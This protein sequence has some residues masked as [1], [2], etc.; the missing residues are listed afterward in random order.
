M[1][2]SRRHDSRLGPE[3]ARSQSQ[4]A[5]IGTAPDDHERELAVLSAILNSVAAWDTFALGSQCL[6]RELAEALGQGAG[7]LLVPKGDYLLRRAIWSTPNIEPEA[8]GGIGAARISRGA[9]LAGRAWE[10]GETV[11]SPPSGRRQIASRSE[12]SAARLHA[13]I[14]VPC[15]HGKEVL[16]VLELYS[17]AQVEL[18]I[19]LMHVLAYAGGVLGAF[20]ARRRGEL[21]LSTLSPR[22]VEVLTL[23]GA[24]LSARELAE[25][26]TI[27]TATVKTHLEHIYAKLGVRDR[28]TAVANAIRAGLIE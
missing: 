1:S 7:A 23:V 9:G 4:E 3:A 13:T 28:T 20:F 18:S 14:A 2:P 24:G 10:C 8:L 22:E 26:L 5:R 15:T 25:R 6:V 17:T 16:G 21:R 27:S 11:D 12:V 19:H